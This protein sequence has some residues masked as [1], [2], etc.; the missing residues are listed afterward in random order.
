MGR[1]SINEPSSSGVAMRS[2]SG[3]FGVVDK[4]GERVGDQLF[5]SSFR[6]AEWVSN[7]FN[8]PWPELHRQGYTVRG[9]FQVNDDMSMGSSK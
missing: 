6:A 3:W 9:G 7:L 4:S 2:S 8:L 5:G 1:N